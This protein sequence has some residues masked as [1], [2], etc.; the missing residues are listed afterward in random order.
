MGFA[1]THFRTEVG[2]FVDLL[3]VDASPFILIYNYSQIYVYSVHI[4]TFFLFAGIFYGSQNI[5][6]LLL[7]RSE[8]LAWKSPR[9]RLFRFHDC[10]PLLRI[11]YSGRSLWRIPCVPGPWFPIAGPTRPTPIAIGLIPI[12]ICRIPPSP[13]EPFQL[14]PRLR[15]GL[16]R[17]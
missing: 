16:R 3:L 7:Q 10:R 11:N 17:D 13:I 8:V 5:K 9:L 1:K 6:C 14:G 12:A 15:L 2:F 4:Y